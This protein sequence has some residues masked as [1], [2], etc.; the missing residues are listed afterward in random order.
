MFPLVAGTS[1]RNTS[2]KTCEPSSAK[3]P[4][5]QTPPES[6][7]DFWQIVMATGGI[8]LMAAVGAVI[9]LVTVI[10]MPLA[11]TGLDRPIAKVFKRCTTSA[12]EC[13]K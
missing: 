8:L 5:S 6:W 3:M 9:I 7:K 13:A 1:G 12:R 4:L 2:G 11:Y 10:R